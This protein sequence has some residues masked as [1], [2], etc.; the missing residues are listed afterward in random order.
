LN[1]FNPDTINSAQSI[2]QQSQE[3]I[4]SF[5]GTIYKWHPIDLF[6]SA[7]QS[8]IL[9]GKIPNFKINFYGVNI[10]AELKE[11]IT[12]HYPALLNKINLFPKT[13]NDLL[14]KE[15]AISNLFLLFN[16]Y[17]ILGTKIFTYLGLKRKILLCFSKDENALTLKDKFYNLEE[18]DTES[19]QLQADLIQETNS[20]IIVKDSHHLQQVLQELYT[21]FEEKGFIACDSV[22]VENYSRKIQV[23]KLAELV[24]E[25]GG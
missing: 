9:E 3:F 16:D 24:K 1:G 19:K 14:V 18:F 7:C 8:L 25:V 21:E 15:L 12:Q 10:H 2:P 23:E 22:G 20:G 11:N 17:S 13:E 6:L 5:A 4:I